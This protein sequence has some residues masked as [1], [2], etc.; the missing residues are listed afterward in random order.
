MF[1]LELDDRY[2]IVADKMNFTLCRI[3]DVKDKQT[4]E[5]TGQREKEIGHFGLHLDQALKRYAT[6]RIRDIDKV[7]VEELVSVLNGLKS[8]IEKVVK[9]ERIMLVPKKKEEG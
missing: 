1:K 3:D 5:I 8:H 9:N 6:E 7:N 4:G 2:F